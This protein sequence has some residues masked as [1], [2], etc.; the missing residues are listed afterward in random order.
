MCAKR[1]I[2]HIHG[3]LNKENNPIIFGYGDES[4]D[5]YKKIEKLNDNEYLKNVKSINYLQTDNYKKM[6]GFINSDYYQVFILGHSCG[7]SDKTLLNTLFEYKNCVSIKPFYYK[8]LT[9][10]IITKKL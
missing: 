8:N 2:I 10:R 9:K 4:A 3:E 7:S 6:L 1:K 5:D